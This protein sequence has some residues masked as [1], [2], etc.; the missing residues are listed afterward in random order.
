MPDYAG[1]LAVFFLPLFPFSMV[2]N[3]VFQ[4]LP[5]PWLK[6]LCL[7]VWPLP[8]LWWLST[9]PP[10]VLDWLPGWAIFTAL[11]Y[12]W[13]ALVIHELGMWTGFIAV[14]DW[15]LVWLG[16]PTQGL[17]HAGMFVLAFSLPLALL[18][19]LTVEIEKRFG[20]AYAG[21]V[22]ALAQHQPRLAGVL[23][24]VMLAIIASPLFPAF[25]AMLSQLSHA[26]ESALAV[27]AGLLG[28][29]LL[30][31]WSAMRLLQDLLSADATAVTCCPPPSDLGAGSILLYGLAVLSLAVLGLWFA[32][33]ML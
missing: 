29:W 31:S 16:Q 26:L 11:L 18:A 28:V 27:T 9:Q 2:F 4:R 14:S 32:G 20:A 30:W 22:N 12:A 13:R 33:V 8:G 6:A 3:V 7:L 23:V 10:L 5:A 15:A 24:L 21:V 19:L 17:Y 25:F 1:W